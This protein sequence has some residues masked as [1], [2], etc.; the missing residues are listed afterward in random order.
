MNVWRTLETVAGQIRRWWAATVDVINGKHCLYQ[1]YKGWYYN[2]FSYWNNYFERYNTSQDLL[3]SEIEMQFHY[4]ALKVDF[5][6][7]FTLWP[8]LA[9]HTNGCVRSCWATFLFIIL[10]VCCE[11]MNGGRRWQR[12]RDTVEPGRGPARRGLHFPPDRTDE[13]APGTRWDQLSSDP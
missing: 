3:F 9:S 10:A 8:Q 2:Y 13:R 12:I 4:H 7:T 1:E 6:L 5:W 11:E